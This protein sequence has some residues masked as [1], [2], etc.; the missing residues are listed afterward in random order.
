MEIN[1]KVNYDKQEYTELIQ[2][3]GE[4][5]NVNYIPLYVKLS[6]YYLHYKIYENAYKFARNGLEIEENDILLCNAGLCLF[7]K[8]SAYLYLFYIGR[9]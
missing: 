1:E 4:L 7:R 5:K 6:S 8:V 2:E 3:A 9:I